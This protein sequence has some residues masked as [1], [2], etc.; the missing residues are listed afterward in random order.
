MELMVSLAIIGIL[1]SVAVPSY[2][3]YITKAK[4][5]NTIEYMAGL[6]NSAATAFATNEGTS[7]IDPVRNPMDFLQCVDF[8]A[9]GGSRSR[10]DCDVVTITAWPNRDFHAS[11]TPGRTRMLVMQGSLDAD[12]NVEW[13]CGPFYN[14]RRTVDV[15]FLP[16]TCRDVIPRPTGRVCRNASQRR[17]AVR[18]Q[19]GR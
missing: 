17:D 18:C 3:T 12:G 8:H 16:T 15:D 4:V 10:D 2:E 6:R 13:K 14:S 19:R 1:A 11:V 5:A 7:F 9:T